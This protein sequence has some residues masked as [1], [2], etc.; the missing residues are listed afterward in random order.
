[1]NIEE[2]K[3]IQRIH[4][5]LKGHENEQGFVVNDIIIVP[6]DVEQQ[7]AFMEEFL[8]NGTVSSHAYDEDSDYEVWA[9]DLRHYEET[10]NVF[11]QKLK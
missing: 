6:A 7:K 2:A 1:M 5:G 3:R 4:M 9:V 8:S 11:F 10:G